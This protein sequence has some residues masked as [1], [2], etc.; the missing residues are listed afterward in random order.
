MAATV[1]IHPILF[2]TGAA[3]AVWAVGV[4]HAVEKGY[5]FFGDG[6]FKNMF[7]ADSEVEQFEDQ[8]SVVQNSSNVLQI[9]VVAMQKHNLSIN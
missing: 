9:L 7:W 1:V 2:V 3:T 5:E 4:V 8:G 6:Q